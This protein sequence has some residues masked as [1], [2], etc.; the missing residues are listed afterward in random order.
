MLYVT[1]EFTV[2][3]DQISAVTKSSMRPYLNIYICGLREVVS[4][5]YSSTL[6]RDCAYMNLVKNTAGIITRAPSEAF[7]ELEEEVR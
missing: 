2:H 6:E 7:A 1:K 3:T 4:I 5:G